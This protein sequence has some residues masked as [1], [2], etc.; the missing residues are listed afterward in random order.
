MKALVIAS[1]NE[2][3]CTEIAAVLRRAGFPVAV[4]SAHR[5][6]GMDGCRETAADF[7]GNAIIKAEHLRHRVP[8]DHWILADDSGLEV[9][10]LNGAPGVFSARYAGEH[11]TDK[12]NCQKLL[13]ALRDYDLPTQRTARFVCFLYLLSHEGRGIVFQGVCEGSILHEKN[14]TNGFG[15]D[16][17]FL[18][19]G[20][21]KS[22]AELS[23]QEKNKISHRAKAMQKFILS[24]T[25]SGDA[26]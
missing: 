25:K 16:P 19:Q 4:Y 1:G 20:Y 17:L 14:G 15:Y 10:A 2:H 12:E 6:G 3:K 23:S 13:N 9:D 24:L 26:V 8:S 5:F 22:F 11:A 21:Q 18:P 7:R